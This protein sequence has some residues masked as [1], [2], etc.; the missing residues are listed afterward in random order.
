MP[1]VTQKQNSGRG[2]CIIEGF[3]RF[4]L[5]FEQ[6]ISIET[7]ARSCSKSTSRR[8]GCVGGF[9]DRLWQ[10]PYLTMF[11]R[12]MDHKLDG[13]AAIVVISPADKHHQ[14]SN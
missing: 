8:K 4:E 14:G 1:G 10:E 13:Q 3:G 9:T 5:G 6:R 11:V 2:G 7:R 12:S